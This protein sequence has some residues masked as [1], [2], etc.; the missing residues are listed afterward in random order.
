MRQAEDETV[1]V[2][3]PFGRDAELACRT[4]TEAGF[5]CRLCR[6]VEDLHVE[7]TGSY[8]LVLLTEEV[9]TEGTV[10]TLAALLDAQPA[11]SSLPVT[12]L[13]GRSTRAPSPIRKSLTDILGSRQSIIFLERPV[14]VA[15]L[16]SVMRSALLARQRQYEL[17]D[18]LIARRKA[19]AHAQMLTQEMSHRMKNSL[20]QIDAIASQTFRPT[21]TMQASLETFSARLR[22]MA[23][24]QDV[25]TQSSDDGA[26]LHQLV[27][28]ALEPYRRHDGSERI[29]ISGPEVRIDGRRSTALTMAVHEL[30]TNA[31]KY[32]A[33]SVD[34]GRV[35]VCWRVEPASG[36]D[37]LWIE[38][39]EQGGPPVTPP[40]RRGFGSRLVERG[41]A[42]EL[43]GEAEIDF[44]PEGVVCR[45][46]APLE[47]TH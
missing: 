35:A 22:S 10:A 39:R 47:G 5:H 6:S 45:I 37:R 40:K 9:L 11:W 17:R 44:R 23:L 36:T 1:L 41:L 4:L 38:W 21:R 7:P 20:S 25:L 30:A 42:M 32:G 12:I 2:L 8:G 29:A 14:R 33:L 34:A 3:A 31:V 18:Q 16:M 28:R 27:S 43:Q 26:S 19:E 24:A 15:T 13:T 46:T